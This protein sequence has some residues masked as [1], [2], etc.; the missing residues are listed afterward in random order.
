MYLALTQSYGVE[1]T[2]RNLEVGHPQN[3]VDSVHG[4]IQTEAESTDILNQ[5]WKTFDICEAGGRAG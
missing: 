5:V 1:V 4:R 2:H 3:E